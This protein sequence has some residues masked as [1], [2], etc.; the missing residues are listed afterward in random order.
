MSMVD[1]FP[2]YSESTSRNSV[3]AYETYNPDGKAVVKD[4]IAEIAP[5]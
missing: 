5:A 1:T 3:Y 2:L 4:G